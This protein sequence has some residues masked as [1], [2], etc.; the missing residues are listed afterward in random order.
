[1]R[2]VESQIKI[3]TAFLVMETSVSRLLEPN[4]NS[5]HSARCSSNSGSKGGLHE[6]LALV[7]PDSAFDQTPGTAP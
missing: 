4:N 1:M 3:V 6:T 7:R 5:G 2:L